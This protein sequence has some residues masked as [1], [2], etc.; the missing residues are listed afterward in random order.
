MIK[1]SMKELFTE[2]T[3]RQQKNY[4]RLVYSYTKN[5]EDA[6]DIIQESIYKALSSLDT[7]KNPFGMKTWFYRIL[8]N[9]SLDYLRKNQHVSVL[10]EEFLE[11]HIPR[12]EQYP[13]IDLQ[14]A[15]SELPPAYRS[16]ILLHYFEDLTLEEVSI[17]LDVN[18]NT[19]KTRL[20]TALKKMRLQM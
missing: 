18:V 12:K 19:V 16:I 9:T 20:Y 10:D 11:N 7:L 5:Q 3:I 13:D 8:V 1:K 17:I 14:K 15:I 4:Y 2:E 6:L